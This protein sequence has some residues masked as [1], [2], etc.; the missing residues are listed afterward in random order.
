MQTTRDQKKKRKNIKREIQLQDSKNSCDS[1]L[2]VTTSKEL[3]VLRFDKVRSSYT[4]IIEGRTWTVRGG[5]CQI[6]EKTEE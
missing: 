4:L 2:V 5:S 3:K 1:Y 6:K